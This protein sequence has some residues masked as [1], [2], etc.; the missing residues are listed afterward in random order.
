MDLFFL[1]SSEIILG[2]SIIAFIITN[3]LVYNYRK[4]TQKMRRN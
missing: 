1:R 2:I 4:E 3:I